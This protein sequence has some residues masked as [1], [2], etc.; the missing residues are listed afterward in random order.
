MTS[1]R[2]IAQVIDIVEVTGDGGNLS[3]LQSVLCILQKTENLMCL[4]L[5]YSFPPPLRRLPINV[6]HNL[7]SLNINA[8]HGVVAPFLAAHPN[9]TE[10][11]LASCDAP[12]CDFIES[13]LPPLQL[14]RTLTCPPGCV[15]GL[16]SAECQL[17][18]LAVFHAS[19][20]DASFPMPQLLNFTPI[21]TSSVLTV[22]YVDFDHETT[23]LLQRISVAAPALAV[24][25]LIE[26]GF[27]PE[28]CL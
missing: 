24:L 20:D 14:L 11:V 5:E 13:L 27:K 17:T 12:T 18:R 16:I 6:Y 4:T 9:I 10:L 23:M 26:S 1:C 25:R 2:L 7:T 22:L 3:S 28:V 8:P 21:Q 19:R 15:Q